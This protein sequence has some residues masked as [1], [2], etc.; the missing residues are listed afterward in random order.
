MLYFY[1]LDILDLNIL[2]L[3]DVIPSAVSVGVL[4][5]RHRR[6]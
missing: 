6:V 2:N 1:G 5:Q 3:E 4:P